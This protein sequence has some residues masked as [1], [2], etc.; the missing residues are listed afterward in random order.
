MTRTLPAVG[1]VIVLAVAVGCQGGAPT[2]FGYKLGADA[3]Y[4]CNI[5][6][7]YVPTFT[8]RAFQTGPYRGLELDLQRAVVREIGRRTR[9]KVVSDP[10]R[11][12][13]ELQANV[14]GIDKSVLN[15]NLQNLIRE[16]DLVLSVDV[17]WRDLRSGEIL[18]APKRGR[19]P[20]PAGVPV[21]PGDA[22]PVFDPT[23][24]TPPPPEVVQF[25]P[26]TRLVATGR[27]LPELG[28]SST[29]AEQR[30]VNAMAIQIVSMMEKPW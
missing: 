30:A 24:P 18:S 19:Q 22:P 16:A 13:T 21:I 26:P 12:D 25:A 14:V 11:A 28:E 23:N 3:L 8:N 20:G 29:T 27:E 5:H 10:E 7:V 1:G 15:R 6:T 9:F 2:V 17:L 4:D